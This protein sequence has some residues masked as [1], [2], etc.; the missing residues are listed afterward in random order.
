[1]S[2]ASPLGAVTRPDPARSPGD[3]H[4]ISVTPSGANDVT[5]SAPTLNDVWLAMNQRSCCVI[6][7]CALKESVCRR[8]P[9]SAPICMSS[10]S[11]SSRSRDAQLGDGSHLAASRLRVRPTSCNRNR[12]RSAPTRHGPSRRRPD[13]RCLAHRLDLEGEGHVNREQA[14]VPI[15]EPCDDLAVGET[16]AASPGKS[17]SS[18]E[19][20]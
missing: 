4:L 17:S 6:H 13:A 16:S 8:Q 2:A 14:L 20:A 15:R 5:W 19:P 9:I 18:V 3:H 7:G 10:L 12:R 11:N 1:M